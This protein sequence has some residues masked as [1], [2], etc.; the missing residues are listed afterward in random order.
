MCLG[1]VFGE[2]SII[3]AES[4]FEMANNLAISGTYISRLEQNLVCEGVNED[5]ESVVISNDFAFDDDIK[6][7][8]SYCSGLAIDFGDIDSIEL[9]TL[10]D[11]LKTVDSAARDIFSETDYQEKSSYVSARALYSKVLTT[12]LKWLSEEHPLVI[13]TLHA[14]NVNNLLAGNIADCISQSEMVLFLRRKVL[15][16]RHP[17]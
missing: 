6:A 7:L 5:G 10:F 4:M 16:E 12:R 2:D 17:R 13:A 11:P 14:A 3:T 15:G 1:S 9:E 8:S